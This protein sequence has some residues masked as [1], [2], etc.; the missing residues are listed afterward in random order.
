MIPYH[1]INRKTAALTQKLDELEAKYAKIQADYTKIKR[2]LD[3]TLHEVRRF[4]GELSSHAE[5]LS[6]QLEEQNADPAACELC[7]T[8]FYTSGMIS[9]RLAFTDLELNPAAV[10][11]QVPLRT[12]IYKKFE[13]AGHVLSL[14][15]RSRHVSIQVKGTSFLEI[16]ALPSFELLPFVILDNAIKYSPPYQSI[17]ARFDESTDR[18][19]L[20]V[21]VSSIGPYMELEEKSMVLERGKRGRHAEQSPVQGD[22]LGLYLAQFLCDYH[23]LRLSIASDPIGKY[24]INGVP[25]AMFTVRINADLTSS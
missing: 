11:L 23:D 2:A 21:V 6:R 15:A 25:Y 20:E 7:E 4:S 1:K 3:S 19:R 5:H 14:K 10:R 9:S 12:G 18:K 17:T 16:E 24:Q 22:G 8:I 13:K